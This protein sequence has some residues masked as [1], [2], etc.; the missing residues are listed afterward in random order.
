MEIPQPTPHII[1][2]SWKSTAVVI[3]MMLTFWVF[4]ASAIDF[5]EGGGQQ[6]VQPSSQM[7]NPAEKIDCAR[8]PACGA[9]PDSAINSALLHD[10]KLVAKDRLMSVFLALDRVSAF[11][12]GPSSEQTEQVKWLNQRVAD[13]K[14]FRDE[15]YWKWGKYC[16]SEKLHKFLSYEYDW[17][18]HDLAL[19]ALFRKPTLALKELAR[20]DHANAGDHHAT[21]PIYA[22]IY[23]YATIKSPQARTVAVSKIMAPYFNKIRKNRWSLESINGILNVREAAS[24]DSRFS[25]LLDDLSVRYT[26]PLVIPCAALIRR[27]G[28]SEA[29]KPQFGGA[30]DGSLPTSDCAT[31]LPPLP[32]LEELKSAVVALQPFCQGTIRFTLWKAYEADILSVRLHNVKLRPV[33]DVAA[34]VANF[35]STHSALVSAAEAEMTRYY[36]RYFGV[37]RALANQQAIEA[38][39]LVISGGY[40]LCEEG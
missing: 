35:R 6:S 18:M 13:W 22:A 16:S 10:P 37:N 19:A 40:N 38:V 3:A 7:A 17:R 5:G 15:D 27:P 24:T 21:A 8:S 29:L 12:I 32:K 1:I 26:M 30:I 14:M 11:G 9:N 4:P 36:T 31:T 2:A 34:K 28:L 39:N 20:F 23:Q 33:D 25:H